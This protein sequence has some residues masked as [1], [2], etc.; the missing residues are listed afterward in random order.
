M[1]C[2]WRFLR[3]IQQQQREPSL[4]LLI[5][6]TYIL[7]YIIT[8]AHI[9][10]QG[11]ELPA[12][13]AFFARTLAE[14]QLGQWQTPTLS[15]TVL[16]AAFAS[17]NHVKRA[18]ARGGL[19]SQISKHSQADGL[20]ATG[21]SCNTQ[22]LKPIRKFHIVSQKCG[23]NGPR[24]LSI[25]H[26]AWRADEWMWQPQRSILH[27]FGCSCVKNKRKDEAQRSMMCFRI[28]A[29]RLDLASVPRF[30]L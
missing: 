13:S 2:A 22:L 21:W 6:D 1:C 26:F 3:Y 12:S 23:D 10:R 11:S 8:I 18:D 4:I 16:S 7:I 20:A 27:H 30:F 5:Y 14:K 17:L 9:V 29:L 28:L 15:L 25:H 24:H 19:A